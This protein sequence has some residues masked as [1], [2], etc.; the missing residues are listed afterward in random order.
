MSRT[1]AVS[2]ATEK[3]E[4]R[5]GPMTSPRS[6][7]CEGRGTDEAED[8]DE[9][10]NIEVHGRAGADTERQQSQHA[11]VVEGVEREHSILGRRR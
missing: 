8:G 11:V 2:A 1:A 10:R 7:N 6:R 5:H 3:G 9:K 4:L